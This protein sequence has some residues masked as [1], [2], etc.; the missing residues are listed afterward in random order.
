VVKARLMIEVQLAVQ[1]KREHLNSHNQFLVYKFSSQI[2]HKLLAN[3]IIT[4]FFFLAQVYRKCIYLL[5]ISIN[6][7]MPQIMSPSA[8][9]KTN[10]KIN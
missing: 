7:L 2:W 4:I 9:R 3:K 1:V 8:E 5:A 10:C 6:Y